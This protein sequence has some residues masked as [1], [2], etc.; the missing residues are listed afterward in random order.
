MVV[1]LRMTKN[2]VMSRIITP[3]RQRIPGTLLKNVFIISGAIYSIAMKSAHGMIPM[4][5][6]CILPCAVSARILP[7]MRTRSRIDRGKALQNR[8]QFASGLA[9]GDDGNGNQLEILAVQAVHHFFPA[10]RPG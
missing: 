2:P 6:A 7:V 10:L 3:I 1:I 5:V 8:G 9:G 4:M